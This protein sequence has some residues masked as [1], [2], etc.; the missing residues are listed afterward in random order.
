MDTAL[1][2]ARQHFLDGIGHFQ[3]G[4]LEPA[5][6]SFE[7][8]LAQAPGRASVLANLGITLFQLRRWLDAVPVLQQAVAADPAQ[9]DAWFA[10]GLC[11][12]AQAQW[13]AAADSLARGLALDPARA[14]LWMACGQCQANAGRMEAALRAFDRVLEIDP[15]AAA[16]WSARGGVLRD[17]G[18][19]D[20]AAPCFEQAIARGADPELHAYYLAAVRGSGGP[21]APPRAYVETLFD[22]YSVDFQSHLVDQLQYRGHEWLLRPLIA[23]R[24]RWRNVLDLG[25][26]TGLCGPLVAPFADAIDGVDLSAAMLAQARALGVYRELIH[27]DLTTFLA[28]TDRRADLVLAADVFIYVGALDAVFG[29]VRRLLEPGGCFAFTVELTP[30]SDDFRL[31]PSLRYAHSEA[32]VRRLAGTHGFRLRELQRAPLRQSQQQ[33]LD[34]LYVYLDAPA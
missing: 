17:L 8:S 12:E 2:Q 6:A 34:A 10:L 24:P 33:A 27:E 4:R 15:R 3:A 30:D 13:A 26:G 14:D 23:S 1:E 19:L 9:T 29:A 31:L 32:Y 28:R 7:A 18:R 25:C 5:R 22:Q 11:H 21:A 20:E 16:A